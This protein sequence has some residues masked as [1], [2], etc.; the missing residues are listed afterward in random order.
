MM[1][2]ALFERLRNR[3]CHIESIPETHDEETE[4]ARRRLEQVQ[5]RLEMVRQAKLEAEILS[6]AGRDRDLRN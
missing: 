6:K 4:R 2:H 5:E 1:I 3:V